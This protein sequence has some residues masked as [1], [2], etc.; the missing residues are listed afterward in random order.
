MSQI[1]TVNAIIKILTEEFTG[2]NKD[3]SHLKIYGITKMLNDAS[4]CI[5]DCFPIR[6]QGRN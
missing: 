1:T 5:S 4:V 2:N 3:V 6:F